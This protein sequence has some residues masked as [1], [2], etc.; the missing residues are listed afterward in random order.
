MARVCRAFCR[1]ADQGG[2]SVRVEQRPLSYYSNDLSNSRFPLIK[3]DTEGSEAT[4]LA[5]GV[6]TIR[7]FAPIIIF[8]CFQRHRPDVLAALTDINYRIARMKG[9]RCRRKI[10]S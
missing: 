2:K 5:S 7:T 1:D 9:L 4:I 8:E 6:D 10:F 3:I